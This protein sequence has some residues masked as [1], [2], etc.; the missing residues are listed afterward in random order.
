M[1]PVSVMDARL[2]TEQQER[3][4]IPLRATCFASICVVGVMVTSLP[5]KQGLRVRFPYFAPFFERKKM[6]EDKKLDFIL[7]T[8]DALC[9]Q[10]H[11]TDDWSDLQKLLSGVVIKD[12]STVTALCWLISTRCIKSKIDYRSLYDRVYEK[13]KDLPDNRDKRL[14]VGLEP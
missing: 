8:V 11:E 3:G 12:I 9:W 10:C 7:Q 4:S 1:W 14:L 5:S 2:S 6:T 13:V